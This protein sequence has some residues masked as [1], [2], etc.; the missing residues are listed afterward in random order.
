MGM[1]IKLKGRQ[2]NTLTYILLIIVIGLLF[3]G[4]E[5]LIEEFIFDNDAIIDIVTAM[6]SVF[7][8]LW[9]RSIKENARL[10]NVPRKH[11]EDTTK[12][13][14]RRVT[15]IAHEFQTPLAILKGNIA[16]L[17]ESTGECTRRP[18]GKT[19]ASR[20]EQT[21]AIYIA[22][23]TLDRLSRLV[24]TLLD[25]AKL[26]FSKDILRR[27]NIDLERLLEDAYEDCE[28]LAEDKG[29][30]IALETAPALVA[31]DPDKL[32][33]VLLNLLSNALKHTP[34][35]G[36]ISVSVNASEDQAIVVV[37]D[38]GPGISAENLPHI[39]ERFYKIDGN[40]DVSGTGL[41]LH[42]C[43]QIVEAHDGTITAET[44]LGKGSRFI[45]RLPLTSY[46]QLVK[47]SPPSA[48]INT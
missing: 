15:E 30:T 20:A 12:E 32:R 39:F 16:V 43:R 27:Q 26:N 10:Q 1:A 23:T 36:I 42:I 33:E 44:E 40:T 35:G 25:V 38:T 21:Q 6:A 8:F 3:F 31:G 37:A 4:I 14:E 41:G 11:S 7:V 48:I 34:T 29:I 28:I 19:D 17:N 9:I 5:S 22:T 47:I 13:L 18:R 24:A 46:R 45:I 2:W